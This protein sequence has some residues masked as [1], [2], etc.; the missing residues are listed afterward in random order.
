VVICSAAPLYAFPWGPLLKPIQ[1]VSVACLFAL[2]GCNPNAP[3]S[4][5]QA[6]VRRQ[7]SAKLKNGMT[8][9][10]VETELGKPTEFRPGAGKRDDVAVYRVNDQTF[11]LYFYRNRLTRY[12]SS[13]K[14]V[15]R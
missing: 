13:Q 4:T 10:E 2:P 7:T 14:P 1:Y 6:Q 3:P 5:P 11:T 9:A 8:E 15:N 12:V